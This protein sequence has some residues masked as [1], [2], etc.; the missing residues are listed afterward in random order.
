MKTAALAAFVAGVLGAAVMSLLTAVARRRGVQVDFESM[1]GT[2]AGGRPTPAVHPEIPGR[3]PTPG[4]YGRFR[5]S[6]RRAWT[7]R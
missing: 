5:R 6:T 3:A 2:I 4:P 7:G 1:L